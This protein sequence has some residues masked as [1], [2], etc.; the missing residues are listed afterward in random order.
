MVPDLVVQFAL[1]KGFSLGDEGG[2][3]DGEVIQCD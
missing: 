1:E 2:G 3:W